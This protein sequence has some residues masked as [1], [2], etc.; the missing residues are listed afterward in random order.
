MHRAELPSELPDAFLTHI[1]RDLGVTPGRLRASDL[2][3]PFRGV[4]VRRETLTADAPEAKH[5]RMAQIYALRMRAGEFFSHLTAALLWGLPLPRHTTHAL[6]R[7]DVAVHAPERSSRGRGVRPHE[8]RQSLVSVVTH[9]LTGLR[10]SSPAST[11]ASLAPMI[12]HPY[13]LVAIG[14]AVVRTPRRPGD[15]PALATLDQLALAMN[16]GRRLGIAQL[17]AAFPRIRTDAWSH[18]ET[19]T[20]LVLVDAG[21][22]EPRCN[23]EVHDKRGVFLATIDLCYPDLMIAIE[24]EGLQHLLD[25]RQWLHD[26]GRYERLVAAGWIVIRV[27]NDQLFGDPAALIRRV[28][29]AIASRVDA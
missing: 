5:V 21:L 3:Y 17:R 25:R 15:R 2:D 14:D 22:A 27:T 11:W 19:W 10:V 6:D 16:A 7:L 8:T 12:P 9:P 4:A 23:L 29:A 24:Y 20:R 28:R 1:A 13:D 26:I 18:R